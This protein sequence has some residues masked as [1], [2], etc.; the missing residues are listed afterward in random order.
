MKSAALPAAEQS[1]TSVP[2]HSFLK[3]VEPHK[4][5]FDTGFIRPSEDS[6]AAD[7]VEDIWDNM[8]V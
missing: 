5:P 2:N 3:L 6:E 4:L 1:D 7:D 8:P